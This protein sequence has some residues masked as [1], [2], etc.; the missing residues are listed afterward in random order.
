MALF[1]MDVKTTNSQENRRKWL[2]INC[3]LKFSHGT[4][5]YF[6]QKFQILIGFYDQTQKFMPQGFIISF[7]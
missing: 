5:K 1:F 7:G 3:T 4:P 2:K 6:A